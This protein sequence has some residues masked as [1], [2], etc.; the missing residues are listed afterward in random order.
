[1]CQLRGFI[2]N[3][4]GLTIHIDLGRIAADFGLLG[5]SQF[6]LFDNAACIPTGARNQIAGQPLLIIHQSFQDM[7]GNQT[8]VPFA[9]R[10]CLSGL[11]ETTR[12]LCELG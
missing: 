6:Q 2:Q 3:L 8:L 7:F 4:G 5:Q 9:Q 1:M 12:P 10:D 11:H